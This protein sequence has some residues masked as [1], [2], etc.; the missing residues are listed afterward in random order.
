MLTV[1]TVRCL[2]EAGNVPEGLKASRS[3]EYGRRFRGVTICWC[4]RDQDGEPGHCAGVARGK[5]PFPIPART[6]DRHAGMDAQHQRGDFFKGVRC[7]GG[8]MRSSPSMVRS[9]FIMRSCWT[10]FPGRRDEAKTETLLVVSDMHFCGIRKAPK[11]S[12][13]LAERSGY[14]KPARSGRC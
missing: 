11:T 1:T 8:D 4:V 13:E 14:W 7:S 9:P 5:L 10:K 2:L 3:A 6:S 12:A